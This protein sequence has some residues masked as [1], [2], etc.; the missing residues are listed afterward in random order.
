MRLIFIGTPEFAVPSLRK[1]DEAGHEIV[2]VFTQPD[3]PVGRKQVVTPPPIKIFAAEHG[4]PVLQPSKIKTDEA[5]RQFE[6]LFKEADAG[7]VA[8]YG[9]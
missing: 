7:V 5:R 6:P 8:A 1:L 2:A 4:L 9:R 3:R